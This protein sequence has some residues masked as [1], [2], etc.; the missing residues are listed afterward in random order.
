MPGLLVEYS[1]T[2]QAAVGVVFTEVGGS[3]NLEE[4]DLCEAAFSNL[5]PGVKMVLK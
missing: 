4:V 5:I 1:S 3:N 2:Y